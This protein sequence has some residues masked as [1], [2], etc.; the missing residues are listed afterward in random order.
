MNEN[1][2]FCVPKLIHYKDKLVL[3]YSSSVDFLVEV[4]RKTYVAKGD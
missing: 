2:Y 3:G 4:S 1:L